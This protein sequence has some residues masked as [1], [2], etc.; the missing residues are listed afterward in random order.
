MNYQDIVK[1]SIKLVTGKRTL[2]QAINFIKYKASSPAEVLN[3]APIVLSVS[4][5]DR[6]NLSCDMCLSHSPRAKDNPYRHK[7]APDMTYELFRQ[8]VDT[9]PTAL[10]IQIVGTGEP[11]LNK[12]Y[13]EMVEYA[14]VEGKMDVSTTSNGTILADKIDEIVAAP[15]TY[16]FVSLNGHNADEFD[17]FTGCGTKCYHKIY[18]NVVS[19]VDKKRSTG[20]SLKIG[21]SYVLDKTNFGFLNDMI[22]VAGRLG[23]DEVKIMPYLS[24]LDIPGYTSKERSLFEE[25][26][27]V[28][29]IFSNITTPA[30][31]HIA[32]Y[33]PLKGAAAKNCK[34]FFTSL[35]VDGA[36]NIGSCGRM[37]LELS[38]NG[39]FTD[40]NVWNND[41]FRRMRRIYLDPEMPL[42]EPCTVCP[43]NM[44]DRI[45]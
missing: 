44:G 43:E 15:L 45:L 3:Y 14:A 9:F 6:C 29:N 12:D 28:K 7:P 24:T 2:V 10:S 8:I 26:N 21:V 5:T 19:L 20:A 23:V 32:L 35:R 42:L 34:T 39:K 27:A 17:R 11:L 22:Q 16:F 13:F 36:G 18:E 31:M 33:P 1:S 40:E 30:G 4:P 38:Q 37:L 25:D 41:Y